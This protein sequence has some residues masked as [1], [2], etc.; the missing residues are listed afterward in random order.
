LAILSINSGYGEIAIVCIEIATYIIQMIA[1]EEEAGKKDW[2]RWRRGLRYGG[3]YR[4]I[5]PNVYEDVVQ[6]LWRRVLRD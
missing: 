2:V 1:L 6:S 3:G 5:I 4:V